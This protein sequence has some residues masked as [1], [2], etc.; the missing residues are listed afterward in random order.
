MKRPK[1]ILVAATILTM[2][3]AGCSKEKSPAAPAF[4]VTFNSNGG[5]AVE[6]QKVPGGE[7]A[8]EPAAPTKTG[9]SF[10]GWFTDNNTFVYKWDFANRPVTSDITLYAQWLVNMRTVAFDSNG[11]SAVEPQAVAEGG[12]L[13]EPTAPA[14]PGNSFGGWFTDNGTFTAQV[15][16]PYTVSTDVTFYAK[17]IPNTVT[18]S[19]DTNG[20]STV[21]P[22][23]GISYGSV[24]TEPAQPTKAANIFAG[25]FLD[26]GTFASRVIF[27]YTVTSTV[28]LYAKWLDANAWVEIRTAADLDAV[29]NNLMGNYMLMNDISLAG[30][31]A[32]TGWKPIGGDEDGASFTGKFD[33][34]GHKITG[35]TINRPSEMVVGLFG[36]LSSG[37]ISNLGVEIATGNVTGSQEAGG[38]AGTMSN[39]TITNCYSTGNVSSLGGYAFAGGIVA[40]ATS[41]TIT[42]CYTTGNISSPYE[43]GGIGAFVNGNTITGC[44]STGSITGGMSGGIAGR[45]FSGTITNCAAINPT[46]SASSAGRIAGVIS[47][48]SASNNFALDVMAVAGGGVFN[49]S[50]PMSYGVSKPIELL[51]TQATYD[52]AV[53]GDGLGGLGWQFGTDDAHPWQMPAGGGYPV[54]YWQK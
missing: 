12:S 5:S 42:N 26:N 38:I 44:Y 22:I 50:D 18:V 3:F 30:Y 24:I 10:G 43:S 6:P 51:Q 4:T 23:T 29:R 54:F 27:P 49:A 16:F 40:F 15:T 1:L 36:N 31:S 14:K 2:A 47:G 39:S 13:S 28:T 8:A 25:W 19:F 48:G 9:N 21:D 34:G 45:L 37:A 20:G 17:W 7:T 41:S 35:L 11:G 53:N 52:G 46:I 32:G 33:G